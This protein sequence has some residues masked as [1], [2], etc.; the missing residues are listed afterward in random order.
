MS[1]EHN[2]DFEP[3][4]SPAPQAS[5]PDER[6]THQLRG[7]E[8][9]A[10][11]TRFQAGQEI[12]QNRETWLNEARNAVALERQQVNLDLNPPYAPQ[13]PIEVEAYERVSHK[14]QRMMA[15]IEA[16]RARRVEQVTGL[17]HATHAHAADVAKPV[18]PRARAHPLKKST[19]A[20]IDQ[21]FEASARIHAQYEHNRAS[22]I[23]ESQAQG[24]PDP[25]GAFE[26]AR[27]DQLD[28]V[29]QGLHKQIHQSF[30]QHGIDRVPAQ[31][32]KQSGPGMS[33]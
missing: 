31:S 3:V 1:D 11:Q 22:F 7:I 20:T 6:V 24:V 25:V 12:N 32:Q 23:Q 30:K 13:K 9:W 29:R 5:A 27:A 2:Q 14:T 17:P 15:G 16:E 10:A 18:E 19:H 8:A 21:A 26:Q 33:G 28:Q 4:Q